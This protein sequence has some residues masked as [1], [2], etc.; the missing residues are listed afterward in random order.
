[1]E[2]KHTKGEWVYNKYTPCDYGVYST[3]GRGNDIAL[4]RGSDDEAEANTK[5]IAAAPDLLNACIELINQ[6]DNGVKINEKLTFTAGM[7]NAMLKIQDA[8]KKATA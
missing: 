2:T 5:L 4:V 3:E 7:V 6:K 8:I 1:M